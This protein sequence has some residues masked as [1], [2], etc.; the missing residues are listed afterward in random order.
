MTVPPP[1]KHRDDTFIEKDYVSRNIGDIIIEEND[2]PFRTYR[3]N[4][5]NAPTDREILLRGTSSISVTMRE[6]TGS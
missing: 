2:D 5:I 1:I 6:V 3:Q 4:A